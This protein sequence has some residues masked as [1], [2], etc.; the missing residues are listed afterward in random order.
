MADFGPFSLCSVL[1][2]TTLLLLLQASFLENINWSKSAPQ[3]Q[4]KAL[5]EACSATSCKL[6]TSAGTCFSQLRRLSGF[7]GQKYMISAFLRI[8]LVRNS[9]MS[10]SF[11]KFKFLGGKLSVYPLRFTVAFSV[12][13][14][15]LLDLSQ[16]SQ[17]QGIREHTES[18][19][20]RRL[21]QAMVVLW[22]DWIVR[23]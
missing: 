10:L 20:S 3:K 18:K 15:H 23:F 12:F 14:R 11:N 17:P 6:G 22:T 8:T 19:I 1:A 4:L 5:L 13:L 2:L 7:A 16:A 21:S 9:M